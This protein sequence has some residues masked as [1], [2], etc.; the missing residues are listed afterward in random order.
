MKTVTKK[1]EYHAYYRT[2]VPDLSSMTKLPWWRA[3]F[4]IILLVRPCTAQRELLFLAGRSFLRFIVNITHLAQ[5]STLKI[6]P[7]DN[8][9]L[10]FWARIMRSRQF[11]ARETIDRACL[12][13]FLAAICLVVYRHFWHGKPHHLHC[14]LCRCS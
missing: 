12:S 7:L 8:A 14:C 13:L 2:V 6:F 3:A 10:K 9:I 11:P 4:L 1:L 5:F